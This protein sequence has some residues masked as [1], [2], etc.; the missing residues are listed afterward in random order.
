MLDGP[1]WFTTSTPTIAYYAQ[2]GNF[3]DLIFCGGATA[4]ASFTGF[5]YSEVKG[6][7]TGYQTYSSLCHANSG[8]ITLPTTWGGW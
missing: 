2:A 4:P 5:W 8:V 7:D 6:E 1:G 3:T